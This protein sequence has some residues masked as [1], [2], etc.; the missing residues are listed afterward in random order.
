MVRYYLK[1]ATFKT[2][3]ELVQC[4]PKQKERAKSSP[5]KHV[6]CSRAQNSQMDLKEFTE[7][8]TLLETDA[9][10]ASRTNFQRRHANRHNLHATTRKQ[11]QLSRDDT[12]TNTIFTRRQANKHKL[13]VTTRKQTQPSRDDKQTNTTFKRRQAKKH[14]LHA[15]TCKQT[16]PSRDKQTNAPHHLSDRQSRY[17]LCIYGL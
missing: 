11:T 16:Q 13:H 3:T 10:I 8:Q 14:N 12:Q 6:S 15:T 17:L 2:K 7:K 9:V 4:C 5:I 1:L